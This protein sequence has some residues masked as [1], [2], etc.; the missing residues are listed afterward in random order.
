MWSRQKSDKAS[1]AKR[2]ELQRAVQNGELIKVMDL[3]AG[4]G[5]P[6]KHLEKAISYAKEAVIVNMDI[7]EWSPSPFNG[8]LNQYVTY[9]N[10]MIT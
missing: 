5:R 10:E 1:R 7:M 9:R 8:D 3:A 4:K 6:R 2:T